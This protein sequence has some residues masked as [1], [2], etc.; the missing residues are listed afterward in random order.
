MF[1]VFLTTLVNASS[2]TKSVSLSK[3]KWGIQ[4]TLMNLHLNEYN[5]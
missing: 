3:Q 5:Q 1:I 2:Q 4:P